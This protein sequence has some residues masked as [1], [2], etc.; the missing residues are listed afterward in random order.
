MPT[1]TQSPSSTKPDPFS[2]P[3]GA[4]QMTQADQRPD[5]SGTKPG[6]APGEDS[7]GGVSAA[8]VSQAQKSA[9]AISGEGDNKSR[10]DVEAGSA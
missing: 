6:S 2:V 3:E 1:G 7:T 10:K 5:S 9:N 4:P 8:A